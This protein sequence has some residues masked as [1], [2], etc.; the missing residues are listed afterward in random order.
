MKEMTYDSLILEAAKYEFSK[1]E[2]L[3]IISE[4]SDNSLHRRAIIEAYI[5]SEWS[6]PISSLLRKLIDKI[7]SKKTM[8]ER[9][10]EAEKSVA[11]FFEKITDWQGSKE[12]QLSD[13]EIKEALEEAEKKSK[14]AISKSIEVLKLYDKLYKPYR[15]TY[16]IIKII[17]RSL[18]Q[19]QR[20]LQSKDVLLVHKII[21]SLQYATGAMLT[22]TKV[23]SGLL[24]A[25]I[26]PFI[27][28][29]DNDLFAMT[30]WYIIIANALMLLIAPF[31]HYMMMKVSIFG[32]RILS[33]PFHMFYKI[34][35][36]FSK[37][38]KEKLKQ[39]EFKDENI[40][41]LKDEAPVE[42][43]LQATG[44][45]FGLA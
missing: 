22:S 39:T 10:Q 23:L 38:A 6:N 18:R 43:P 33:F 27:K 1:Y 31:Y 19:I 21:R 34:L 16:N 4:T 20:I 40:T 9:C 5:L 12:I 44:P 2:Y 37:E 24:V 13:E 11:S 26:T 36:F 41:G 17:I 25:V 45:E 28:H 14:D 3:S 30:K 32:T 7:Q 15:P 8:K 35:A 42:T 29:T